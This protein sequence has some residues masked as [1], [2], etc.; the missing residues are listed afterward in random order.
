M[1]L[2]LVRDPLEI[3][4]YKI[5]PDRAKE[6]YFAETML[7]ALQCRGDP[8]S[9]YTGIE[10][11]GHLQWGN[12]TS[13]MPLV[14]MEK[15]HNVRPVFLNATEHKYLNLRGMTEKYENV[16]REE[17]K[18]QLISQ[19]VEIDDI[20]DAEFDRRV[21]R[22]TEEKIRERIDKNAEIITTEINH[23]FADPKIYYGR[24]FQFTDPYWRSVFENM[25]QVPFKRMAEASAEVVSDNTSTASIIYTA[26][27]ATDVEWLRYKENVRVAVGGEDQLL[28]HMIVRDYFTKYGY[29][30]PIMIHAPILI[31]L[32]GK[33]EQDPIKPG[34]YRVRKMSKSEGYKYV[35]FL[36]DPPDL[37]KKKIEQAACPT[38]APRLDTNTIT[39]LGSP[40]PLEFNPII[41]LIAKIIDPVQFKMKIE[42]DSKYGGDIEQEPR[43]IIRMFK[44]SEIHPADLKMGVAETIAKIN[45]D[46]GVQPSDFSDEENNL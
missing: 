44:K 30:V 37:I 42:R 1:V 17:I 36:C 46:L 40:K 35:L 29:P 5:L 39:D 4:E 6:P 28:I 2:K 13:M 10:S 21:K 25:L 3:G 41:Q 14:S 34:Q 12:V 9:A 32:S 20:G 31:S 38:Y 16:A 26:A 8:I 18:R 24:D 43:K 22:L 27:Q 11:S 23:L 33:I 15:N 19:Y 45:K 7:M